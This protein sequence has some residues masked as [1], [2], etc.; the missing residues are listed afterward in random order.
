MGMSRILIADDDPQILEMLQTILI[1]DGHQ[2]VTATDGKTARSLYEAEPFDLLVTDIVLPEKEGLDLIMEL[3]E[4]FPDLKAIA[5]S[6]GDHIEPTYYLEL[7]SILGAQQTLSK[8]FTPDEFLQKV[9][10]V[11]HGQGDVPPGGFSTIPRKNRIPKH[12]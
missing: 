7:A 4:R 10:Q 5:I 11:L 1:R 9:R 12:S 6:G 8:P 3:D 2:V